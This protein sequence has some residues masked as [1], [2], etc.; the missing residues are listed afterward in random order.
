MEAHFADMVVDP[1]PASYTSGRYP[2]INPEP[3][4][5][6]TLSCMGVYEQHHM[7]ADCWNNLY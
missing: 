7:G 4:D 1:L 5:G 2:L 3:R 6:L